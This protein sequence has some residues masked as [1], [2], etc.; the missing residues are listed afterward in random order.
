MEEGLNFA[1]VMDDATIAWPL[2]AIS[3][4][5]RL[6][7]KKIKKTIF[8]GKKAMEEINRIVNKSYQ[9]LSVDR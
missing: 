6:K 3:A 9:I 5:R 1:E 8:S 2:I 4:M 7:G